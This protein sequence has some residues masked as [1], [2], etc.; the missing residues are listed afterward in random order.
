MYRETT[1]IQEANEERG[2]DSESARSILYATWYYTTDE[3]YI[4]E[5]VR[6]GEDMPPDGR[7]Q[8]LLLSIVLRKKDQPGSCEEEEN[9]GGRMY[10]LRPGPNLLILTQCKY[11]S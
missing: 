5:Q 1:K 10:L 6:P 4:Q 11:Q 3:L 2:K 7:E 8:A 9:T